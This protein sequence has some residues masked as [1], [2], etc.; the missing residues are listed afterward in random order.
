MKILS[1]ELECRSF[2]ER[3]L[4]HFP[5][6]MI[7][8]NGHN[9]TGDTSSGVGKST[10]PIAIAFA[11]GFADIPATELKNWETGK[12]H[13]HL[14]LQVGS[15]IIDIIR[16]P[17]LQLIVNGVSCTGTSTAHEQELQK[18]LGVDTAIIKA[19]THRPQR[20]FG[21]FLGMT[22]SKKK[23]FLTKV[24]NLAEVESGIDALDGQVKDLARK[25][26]VLVGRIDQTQ[27]MRSNQQVP[28]IDKLPELESQIAQLRSELETDN[29]KIQQVVKAC[30]DEISQYQA[31]KHKLY[32]MQNEKAQAEN[33]LAQIKTT[34]I[35]LNGE[36]NSLKAQKCWTCEREWHD[37][38]VLQLIEEKNTQL[39]QLKQSYNSALN[40]VRSVKEVNITEHVQLFDSKI[41]ELHSRI[42]TTSGST[43]EKTQKLSLLQQHLT[44]INQSVQNHKH[45]ADSLQ[46]LEQERAE[47]LV[48][49]HVLEHA[50]ALLGRQGFLG[51]I[52]DEILQDI[53]TQANAIIQHI[54]NVEDIRIKIDSTSV[55]AKGKINKSINTQA[56][57]DGKPIKIRTL[58]GGQQ[59]SLELATDLAVSSVIRNRSGVTFDWIVLDEAM[60]GLDIN[61]KMQTLDI[62]KQ[63]CSGQIIVIDHSTEIK[64]SFNKV[65]NLQYDGK[66][67]YVVE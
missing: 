40:V 62:I 13:V 44:S 10:I 54:P 47:L 50:I 32:T 61:T 4:I 1:L 43:T 15:D 16:N 22:D 12:L 51:S 48:E 2:K 38:K 55:T 21:M 35:T 11:L 45:L 66:Q 23:E 7:L 56:I 36:L 33:N 59:A 27:M 67:T 60:D 14:K 25:I 65:I 19:L 52:F 30:Q 20:S 42:A 26:E 64:E 41:Q 18:I 37:S 53:Q 8:I 28:E 17:K 57:K 46:K 39:K 5:E 58:S 31:E 24:L 6:G 34:A 9:P 29:P 3:Q 49:Q 63:I